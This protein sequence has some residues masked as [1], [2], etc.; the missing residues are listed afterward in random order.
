MGIK[1]FPYQ[2]GDPRTDMGIVQ[3]QTR[4]GLGFV[5]I[6]DF[7]FLSP[8]WNGIQNGDPILKRRSR[9]GLGR[10]LS[11][12][13]IRE[14]QNWF[15]VHSNLGTNTHT[16]CT[17]DLIPRTSD[18]LF[19]GWQK[20]HR[21]STQV[22]QVPACDKFGPT[23]QVP[24]QKSTVLGHSPQAAITAGKQSAAGGGQESSQAH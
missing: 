20:H 3:S 21:R 15:G 12:F 13:Q 16:V 7:R 10:D 5:P 22:K 1:T 19:K 18:S 9:I 8:N 17:V 11:I 6:W 23:H 24:H 4:I 2:N 14:S